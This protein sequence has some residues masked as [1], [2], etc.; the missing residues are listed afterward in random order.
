MQL[1]ARLDS[2]WVR[3]M[4]LLARLHSVWVRPMQLLARL[5]SMRV[6][7]LADHWGSH[8][9]TCMCGSMQKKGLGPLVVRLVDKRRGKCG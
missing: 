1:L 7:G 2:V 4:Q 6:P 8:Y 5:H 3:S 9:R